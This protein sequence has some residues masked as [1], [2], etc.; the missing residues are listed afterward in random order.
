MNGRGCCSHT[1]LPWARADTTIP[2]APIS[3]PVQAVRDPTGRN[4]VVLERRDGSALVR[5]VADGVEREVMTDGWTTV[6]DADVLAALGTSIPAEA[7][8]LPHGDERAA[9]LLV[10]VAVADPLPVRRLMTLTEACESD[11]VPWT[12]ALRDAGLIERVE[13]GG[14]PGYRTTR[15]GRSL[16][17]SLR[18]QR[19]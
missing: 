4:A 3:T 6:P 5:F 8:L 2:V 13:A 12:A 9:G 18:E 19:G 10:A 14:T 11:V 16:A 15:D 7:P 17:D 1:N